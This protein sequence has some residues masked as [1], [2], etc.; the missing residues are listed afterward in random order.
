MT[1]KVYSTP[2]CPYCIQAKKY[3]DEHN[4]SYENTDVSSNSEAAKE[5]INKSGQR[6]VP[7]LDINGEIVLGFD[8]EKIDRLLN[9]N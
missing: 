3:L 7:V 9:I 8:K 6:G 4:I 1:V 2:T 5:M